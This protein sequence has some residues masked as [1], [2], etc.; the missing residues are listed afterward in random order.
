MAQSRKSP[1]AALTPN[2]K[3]SALA[4]SVCPVAC[5]LDL[6]GDKWTL[7]VIRDLLFGKAHF[8]EFMA[9]PEHVAT[10]ILTERL[11]RLSD[12]GLIERYPSEVFP[13]REAYRLTAKGK[14]LTPLL[15][16]MAAWGLKHIEG[17][18][19]RLKA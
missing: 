15:E 11:V 12:S 18:S 9:S 7:L 16:Q 5:T 2:H 19:A 3:P 6:I 8:K 14:S 10:N 1:R 13:G 4:R 17:T